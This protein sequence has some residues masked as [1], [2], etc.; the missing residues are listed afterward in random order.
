MHKKS[1]S[2]LSLVVF[3]AFSTLTACTISL[4]SIQTSPSS[5]KG[6]TTGQTNTTSPNSST[7]TSNSNNTSTDPQNGN[8]TNKASDANP[9]NNS[10]NTTVSSPAPTSSATSTPTPTPSP[11]ST[12]YTSVNGQSAGQLNITINPTFPSQRP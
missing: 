10:G 8:L 6:N 7:N 3:I 9:I 1:L 11:T 4:P 2:R 5:D 12:S